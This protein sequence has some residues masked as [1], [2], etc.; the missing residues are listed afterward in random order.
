M[1]LYAWRWINFDPFGIIRSAE[2]L[3]E[4]LLAYRAVLVAL[5]D[6]SSKLLS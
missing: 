5:L 4:I 1:L 3:T 2:G 6:S